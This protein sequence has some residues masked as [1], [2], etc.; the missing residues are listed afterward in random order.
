MK[1]KT[2]LAIGTAAVLI[3]GTATA[4]MVSLTNKQNDSMKTTR[5]TETKEEIVFDIAD[6][7][8]QA[9]KDDYVKKHL[10]FLESKEYERISSTGGKFVTEI[11]NAL[12]DSNINAANKTWDQLSSF[13]VAAGTGELDEGAKNNLQI[14]NKYDLM[15][16]YL[17]KSTASEENFATNGNRI[18]LDSMAEILEKIKEILSDTEG[19]ADSF[20]EGGLDKAADV[21]E[22]IDGL[23]STIQEFQGVEPEQIQSCYQEVLDTVKEKIN[24]EFL[25]EDQSVLKKKLLALKGAEFLTSITADTYEDCMNALVLYTACEEAADM[26]CKT[27]DKIAD[28]AETEGTKESRLLE[29]SIRTIL[30]EIKKHKEDHTK[31]LI[32]KMLKKGGENTVIQAIQFLHEEWMDS[33]SVWSVGNAIKNGSIAGVKLANL[34]TN[35]DAI[36]YN[37][38]MLISAGNLADLCWEIMIDAEKNLDR[39]KDFDSAVAFDQIFNIYKETQIT[40]CDYAIYYYTSI[41][42]APVGYVFKYTSDDE[43][44]ASVVVLSEKAYWES[45]F[46]HKEDRHAINNGG[47]FVGYR[48]NTYYW[49]FAPGAVEE[50][51]ILGGFSQVEEVQNELICRSNN[52]KETVLLKDNGSGPIYIC[53]NSIFYERTHGNWEICDLKGTKKGSYNQKNIQD[54]NA[55]DGIIVVSDFNGDV[56][57]YHADGSNTKL[58][59]SEDLYIGYR[60]GILYYGKQEEAAVDIYSYLISAKH[61]SKIGTLALSDDYSFGMTVIEDVQLHKGNLYFSCG[62]MGGTGMVFSNGG[63]YRINSMETLETLVDAKGSTRVGM[64]KF[65]IQDQKEQSILYFYSGDGYSTAGFWDIWTDDYICEIDLETKTVKNSEFRLSNIGDNLC[66]DGEVL[67]LVDSSGEYQTVLSR[68]QG[69]ELGYTDIG[70][71]SGDS[72]VFVRHLDLVKDVAYFTITKITEDPSG[73]IGWRT[74][75]TR[76]TMKTY[77]TKLE[78]GEFEL[79]NEY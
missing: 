40:A 78:S 53:G 31:A 73:G 52:G 54:V 23:L 19:V 5:Q 62:Y 17:M 60:K 25:P 45:Y 46:C 69:E 20:S 65:Y 34:V 51:G 10:N 59:T 26:W 68:E 67:T 28:A 49:R 4:M 22:T 56:F 29:K 63:I 15:V 70:D 21:A 64:P 8:E 12:E 24:K 71:D 18:L 35:C 79:I 37:C 61:E 75:Y 44:G 41:A 42:S 55:E 47:R 50:K 9:Y 7:M 48:G 13:F 27:W 16:S 11:A 39:K 76:E 38:E 1:K 43:T 33:M 57:L 14:N 77:R 36:A 30:G 32:E 2:M 72:Q 58:D 74:A 66:V 3:M 6:D